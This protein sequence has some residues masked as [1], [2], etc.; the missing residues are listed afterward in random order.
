MNLKTPSVLI[1]AFI[2]GFLANLHAQPGYA[3]EWKKTRLYGH[4]YAPGGFTQEQYQWIVDHHEIFCFEKTHLR[5]VY[6]NPS[7]EV[8]SI[9]EAAYLKTLNPRIKPITIY[10]INTAYPLWN[11]ST[12]KVLE[13]HPEWA[14][15][16]DGSKYKWDLSIE[17]RNDWYVETMNNLVNNSELEGIFIDGVEGAY[18]THG[19]EI[20]S[21]MSRM[22]GLSLMNG[23]NPKNA[24]TWKTGPDFLEHSAGVFVDSWFRRE[25]DTKEGAVTMIDACIN[26]PEEKVLILFSG[27]NNDGIWGTD[28]T[29]SHAAYLIV[30]NENTYYRWTGD[31]LWAPDGMM[32][33]HEDFDKEMGEPLGDAVKSGYV[34]KR[35][36]KYCT[37]TLDVENATSNIEWGQNNEE[38]PKP[39]YENVA[40][41]GT[42][43]QSTTDYNGDASLAIDNNNNGVYNDGSVSHTSAEDDAW[44]EVTLADAF[45]IG[46]ITIYNRTDS[47]MDR[48][49]DFTVQVL[50]SNGLVVF[51][52]RITSYPNP[53]T[54]V[55]AGDVIGKQVRILQNS[56]A[57]PL[58]L[59]EVI[60]NGYSDSTLSSGDIVFND[61]STWINIYPNPVEDLVNI[62]LGN[63]AS[64]SYQIFT[65]TGKILRSGIINN[66][67]A[68][69]D[70]SDLAP[71]FYLI[72]V[73]GE[74]ISQVKKIIVN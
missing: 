58:S 1:I 43:T 16:D 62:K 6:G 18:S 49:E 69:I 41:N 3:G 2:V 37:V 26:I 59:A 42:A 61:S 55:N 47:R 28:H 45:A 65:T 52:H 21:M 8:S 39:N 73:S 10:S 53:S 5:S 33:Y 13:D 54:T 68:A 71:G 56:A 60:V 36:F 12:A 11:E 63:T 20:K 67:N 4:T 19:N 57:T 7:H 51:E 38:Q 34:Y 70:L 50:D 64:V 48:L 35:V 44:W 46:E 24:T 72:K 9:D 29:F 40:L 25:L 27:N 17:D 32:E 30:A 74:S 31:G 23:F 22:D 66:G 14:T 15:T